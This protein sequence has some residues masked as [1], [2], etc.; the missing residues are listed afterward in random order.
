MG[1]VRDRIRGRSG[2]RVV[3]FSIFA[4]D[5]F[6]DCLAAVWSFGEVGQ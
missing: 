2:R 1:D 6:V 3:V 4:A 5:F